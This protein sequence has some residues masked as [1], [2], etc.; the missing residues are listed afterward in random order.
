MSYAW[1]RACIVFNL[2]FGWSQSFAWW[3]KCKRCATYFHGS[4]RSAATHINLANLI[5][6][7]T[8]MMRIAMTVKQP[9]SWREGSIR[10][11]LGQFYVRVSEGC[12]I[13]T[14]DSPG[15]TVLH[16]K[17]YPSLVGLASKT[18]LPRLV[19]EQLIAHVALAEAWKFQRVHGSVRQ[20]ITCKTTH[21]LKV[22]KWHSNNELIFFCAFP[23]QYQVFFEL[24]KI[25]AKICNA[26]SDYRVEEIGAKWTEMEKKKTFPLLNADF[27]GTYFIAP[28]NSFFHSSLKS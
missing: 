23:R 26:E 13:H 22:V 21:P 7:C 2:S 18:C 14:W 28:A 1:K 24:V 19:A 16:V 27:L 10:V 4:I 8:T 15:C 11:F 3:K 5:G 9:A 17:A 12:P 20:D 25:N 6:H